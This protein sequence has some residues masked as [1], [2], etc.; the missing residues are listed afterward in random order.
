MTDLRLA[1]AN[2]PTDEYYLNP[3]LLA[4]TLPTRLPNGLQFDFCCAAGALGFDG[5]G[6]WFEWPFITLGILDPRDFVIIVKTLT[7]EARKGNYDPWRPWTCVRL[8]RG[9]MINAMGLPNMGYERWIR[10]CYPMIIERGYRAIVSIQPTNRKEAWDMSR[11]LNL[12][13]IEGIEVNLSCPNTK[14]EYDPVEIIK[15]VR[16]CTALPVI[17]KLGYSSVVGDVSYMQG[18]D[19]YV[20]A[21]DLINTVPWNELHKTPSPLAGYKLMGGVSGEQIIPHAREALHVTKT[22]MH[23]GILAKKPVISGGGIGSLN[24]AVIRRNLG[25]DS[26]SLGT[27]FPRSILKFDPWL[28]NRIVREYRR[29]YGE[30]MP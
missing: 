12:N 20:D 2:T 27:V 7:Y 3:E 13:H 19:P 23:A 16:Y 15:T 26:L 6:Y 4:T 28:P 18:I 25:A 9:G 22:R 30:K 24:E 10:D 11:R 21:W 8:V 14:D 29:L 17:A 5:D 1:L